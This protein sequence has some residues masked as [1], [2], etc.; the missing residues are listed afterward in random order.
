MLAGVLEVFGVLGV[1][2][3]TTTLLDVVVIGVPSVGVPVSV[4]VFV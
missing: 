3:F 2:T 4:A 1:A